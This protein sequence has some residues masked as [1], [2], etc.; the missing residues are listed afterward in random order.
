[1]KR[2]VLTVRSIILLL[3]MVMGLALPVARSV[4][5][6]TGSVDFAPGDASQLFAI[7]KEMWSN[8]NQ[9]AFLVCMDT[10]GVNATLNQRLRSLPGYAELHSSCQVWAEI[11]FPALQ[12]LAAELSNG[13]MKTLLLR[14][15]A[16]LRNL[17]NNTSGAREEFE[18]AAD[19]INHKLA[20]LSEI[21]RQV[22]QQSMT[23]YNASNIVIAQYKKSNV[24]DSPWVNIGPKLEDVGL[25][26]SS[27]VGRWNLLASNLAY[28]RKTIELPAG[29]AGI[30]V[31][32]DLDIE[33]GLN[34]WDEIAQRASRFLQDVPAQR[35]Y[36]SGENYYEN[37]TR[38]ENQWYE[39]TNS[40]LLT[41]GYVLTAQRSGAVSSGPNHTANIVMKLREQQPEKVRY[42]KDSYDDAWSQQW[43]FHR[44]EKGW[45]SIESRIRNDVGYPSFQFL[46]DSSVQVKRI[47]G[48]AGW[49]HPPQNFWWRCLQSKSPGWFRLVNASLG[50]LKFLDT[51]NEEGN[52]F[53]GF[54]GDTKN[55]YTGQ[56]WKFEPVG[57]P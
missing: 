40:F 21:S 1:M 10:P 8:I 34:A 16:A 31:L 3:L 11:T 30:P 42:Y 9:F 7:P 41:K 32:Y 29:T 49:A 36:L 55:D 22:N 19:K 18:Q 14:L 23:F 45:W 27:M 25:A 54:M 51:H 33:V 56:Y 38:N 50:D 53:P 28:L 2:C 4:A 17:P 20:T 35:K 37:C 57:S 39:M 44:L 48:Q 46:L 43:R 12:A 26:L 47:E 24:P 5:V 15:Q 13:E 52:F 6:E